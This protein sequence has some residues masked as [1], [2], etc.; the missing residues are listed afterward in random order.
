MRL[1]VVFIFI[2]VGLAAQAQEVKLPPDAARFYLEVY[3][4][5]KILEKRDSL[6]QLLVGNLQS[7]NSAKNLLIQNLE[8][9]NRILKEI[10][11]IKE[12][13]ITLRDEEVKYLKKQ[14]RKQKTKTVLTAIGSGALILLILL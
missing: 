13:E 6:N 3:D 8:S 14:L 10:S 11:S 1:I 12:Q 9:S 4:K 2:V 5:Y 7:E